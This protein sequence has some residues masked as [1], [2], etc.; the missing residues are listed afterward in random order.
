MRKGLVAAAL[1]A[2]WIVSGCF[3]KV[4]AVPIIDEAMDVISQHGGGSGGV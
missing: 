1:L 3:E 4:Q 2:V